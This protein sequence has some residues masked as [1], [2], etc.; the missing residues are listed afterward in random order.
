MDNQILTEMQK[1]YPEMAKDYQGQ[2]QCIF[3]RNTSATDPGNR[4]PYDTSGFEGLNQQM[5]MFFRVPDDLAGLDISNGQCYNSSIP[6]NVTFG[7]QGLPF[8]I[9]DASNGAGRGIG[10]PE[11]RLGMISGTV[12]ALIGGVAFFGW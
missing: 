3:L 8:G 6:Q 12:L 4:F 5:Y 11:Y 10:K 1:A 2:V 7:F 9:G